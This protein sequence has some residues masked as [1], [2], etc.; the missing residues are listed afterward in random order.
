M[1][2]FPRTLMFVLSLG[3]AGCASQPKPVAV[4]APP[5]APLAAPAPPPAPPVA[6]APKAVTA[7]FSGSNWSFT[8]PDASWEADDTTG[9]QEL[10]ASV[11]NAK[12]KR[13]VVLIAKEAPPGVTTVD[14]A[15]LVFANA[16]GKD[17]TT[18]SAPKP[19]TLNGTDFIIASSNNKEDNISINLWLT[20]KDNIGYVFM[21][22]GV[23]AD[24]LTDV[25]NGIAT[26]L[27]LK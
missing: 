10:L 18:I 8:C 1:N 5:P 6:P 24:D 14:F 15:A 27:Q 20:V 3:L 7:Q 25:C 17:G 9:H 16:E 2:S 4:N 21:C 11:T 22:G 23:T 26:T 13:R 12:D 19:V